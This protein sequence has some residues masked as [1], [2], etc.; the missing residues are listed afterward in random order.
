[1]AVL[2]WGAVGATE[3]YGRGQQDA[4]ERKL[5][6][7][8]VDGQIVSLRAAGGLSLGMQCF[9]AAGQPHSDTDAG[10]PCSYNSRGTASGCLG[11]NGTWCYIVRIAAGATKAV[12][13]SANVA[14]TYTVTVL[15]PTSQKAVV[16]YRLIQSNQDYSIQKASAAIGG[17]EYSGGDSPT[18]GNRGTSMVT[19]VIPR[20]ADISGGPSV[21]LGVPV[22]KASDPC[23]GTAGHYIVAPRFTVVTNV[24]D[25]L[26]NGC[27]WDFGDASALLQIA[28]GRSGCKNGEVVGHDYQDDWQMQNLP[29]YPQSC[30]APLGSGVDTH[31]FLV[32]LTLHTTEGVDVVSGSPLRIILPSCG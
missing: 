12:A 32:R 7:T 30:L 21:S 8:I 27:S 10:A 24:P 9:D 29:S 28:A 2:L 15:W 13:D 18:A 14:V 20:L 5:A 23:Y 25:S 6:Q 31:A 17:M 3:R 26:I 1:M 4:H 22:C 16:V 19:K 11:G